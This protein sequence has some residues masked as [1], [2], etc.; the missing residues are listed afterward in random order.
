MH[1]PSCIFGKSA[2]GNRSFQ[3]TWFNRFNWLHYDSTN[4]SVHCFTCCKA[5]KSGKAVTNDVTEQAFLVKGCT[6]WKNGTRCFSTHE[7]C[8]FH[9]VCPAALASI[10]DVG[11]ILSQQAAIEKQANHEYLLKQILCVQFFARQRLALG[12][13]VDEVDSNLHQLLLL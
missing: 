13:D 11:D 3:V 5:V 10:V 1:F 7:S 4:D 12:G 6:N 2:T 9:K 8:D